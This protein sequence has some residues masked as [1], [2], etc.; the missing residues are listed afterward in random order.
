MLQAEGGEELWRGRN[1]VALRREQ[2][3]AEHD[4][5]GLPQRRHHVRRLA[6][7]EGV[8]TAAQR[9]AVDGVAGALSGGECRN[10]GVC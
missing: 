9:L 3:M 4:L 8:E 10:R 6:V 5:I 1:L 2:Q 7:A